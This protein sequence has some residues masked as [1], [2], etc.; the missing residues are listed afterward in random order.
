[1]VGLR[2]TGDHGKGAPASQAAPSIFDARYVRWLSQLKDR[3]HKLAMN[4][5]RRPSGEGLPAADGDTADLPQNG[6]DT[7]AALQRCLLC[8]CILHFIP[9]PSLPVTSSVKA[10]L[11]NI[12][13]TRLT[14]PY[15]YSYHMCHRREVDALKVQLERAHKERELSTRPQSSPAHEQELQAAKAHAQQAAAASAQHLKELTALKGQRTLLLSCPRPW[16]FGSHR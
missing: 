16:T 1:M 13:S 10:S 14:Y 9:L 4:G 12:K 2:I 11:N 5:L 8:L 6:Q 3:M 7:A 15:S